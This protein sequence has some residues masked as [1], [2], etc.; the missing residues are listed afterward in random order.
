LLTVQKQEKAMM[1]MLAHE[2]E[3]QEKQLRS[4]HRNAA[5]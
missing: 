4:A 3:V 5:I 1:E 2:K